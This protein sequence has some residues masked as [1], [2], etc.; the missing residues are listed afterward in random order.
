MY[1]TRIRGD[2]SVIEV[3]HKVGPS[4]DVERKWQ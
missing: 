4:G 3:A 2:L 1:S